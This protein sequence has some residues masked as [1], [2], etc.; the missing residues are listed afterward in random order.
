MALPLTMDAAASRGPR[1]LHDPRPEIRAGVAL[2]AALVLGFGGWAVATRLDAAV[3]GAGMVRFAGT[4]QVVQAPT[5]GI[6]SAVR[7]RNGAAVQAGQTL[8]EFTTSETR[9]QAQ[10]LSARVVGLMAEIARLETDLAG[11]ARIVVPAAFAS[12]TGDERALADKALAGQQAQLDADRTLERSEAAV[13]NDRS[14]QI[15]QQIG[16]YG[17]RLSSIRQQRDLNEQELAAYQQLLAKGLATRSRVLALQRSAAG[18]SG[19]AGAS[20]AEIGRLRLQAGETRLQLN[21][22]RSQRIAAASDRLRAAQGELQATLPQWHAARAELARMVVRA[23]FAGTI[24]AAQLPAAGAVL[25]AGAP[26]MEVVPD[27]GEMTVELRVPLTE[28]AELQTGQ[29]AEVR[30]VGP[31]ARVQPALHGRVDRISADTVEDQRTGQSYYTASIAVSRQ[32]LQQAARDGAMAGGIRAGTPVEVMIPTQAR[33]AI[34][35]LLGPLLS[36]TSTVFTQR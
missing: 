19:D 33:R 11:G 29:A 14:R 21:H 16:G 24:S 34:D 28:A 35:F 7:V 36:R 30:L 20:V 9:A 2:T 10:S 3:V 22:S 18:L 13:L 26:L 27:R 6:V 1:A 15:A 31:G 23:P 4:R 32:A 8:V 5:G 25:P 17:E 12:M